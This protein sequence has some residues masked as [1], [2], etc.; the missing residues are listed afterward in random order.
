MRYASLGAKHY[1]DS[2]T[3]EQAELFMQS[4]TEAALLRI[5]GYDRKANNSCIPIISIDSS[6][7]QFHADINVTQYYL[8]NGLDNDSAAWNCSRIISIDSPESHGMID[9]NVTVTSNTTDT[10][11]KVGSPVKL[12]RR[13]LQRP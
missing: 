3:R 7:G 5:S 10:T 9:I 13:S 8:Y 11:K 2:Y 6:D 4:A 12:I 1:S